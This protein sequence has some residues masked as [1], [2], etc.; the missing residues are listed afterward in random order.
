MNFN[1]FAPL[2]RFSNKHW[3]NP[4]FHTHRSAFSRY[5]DA[6]LFCYY[7]IAAAEACKDLQLQSQSPN[8]G[9]NNEL[10][11]ERNSSLFHYWCEKRETTS[12]KGGGMKWR[13]NIEEFN[14]RIQIQFVCIINRGGWLYEKNHQYPHGAVCISKTN[15]LGLFQHQQFFHTPSALLAALWS[16]LMALIWQQHTHFWMIFIFIR[17]HI[18]YHFT[19]LRH[20]NWQWVVTLIKPPSIFDYFT[21]LICAGMLDHFAYMLATFLSSP[22][23]RRRRSREWSQKVWILFS[24]PNILP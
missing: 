11:D 2:K 21:Y 12:F 9:M 20:V 24:L 23:Q 19:L 18:F 22:I 13:H 3:W 14:G 7:I 4:L 8:R 15:V 10:I 5:L 16:R 17:N 1:G 6:H